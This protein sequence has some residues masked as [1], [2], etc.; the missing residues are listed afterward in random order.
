MGL[1]PIIWKTERVDSTSGLV[2][3]IRL[4][5]GG[6]FHDSCRQLGRNFTFDD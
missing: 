1:K 6:V 3:E 5:R 2:V 4:S